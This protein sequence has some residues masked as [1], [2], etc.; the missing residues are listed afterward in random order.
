V[1]AD[2]LVYPGRHLIVVRPDPD[3]RV[4]R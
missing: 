4:T 2:S 1:R 3:E